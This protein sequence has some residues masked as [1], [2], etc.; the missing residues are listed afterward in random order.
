MIIG[1]TLYC[2]CID[3][4]LCRCLTLEEAKKVL[5]ECHL[6]ACGRNLS[7]YTTT[8]NILHIDYLWP[9]IFHDCILAVQKCH[10]C[11]V[12]DKKFCSLPTPLHSVVIVGPFVKWGIDFMTCNLHSTWGHGYIIV[13][14]DYFTKWVEEMPTFN[15]V[16]KTAAYFFFNHSTNNSNISQEALLESYDDQISFQIGTFTWKF[17]S[18]LSSGFNVW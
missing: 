4:I 7:G 15:N 5:N 1:D 9:T 8:Q 6:G 11:Q 10:A 18:L 17:Y 16:G 12:Y 2:C 3:T 13:F 14:V